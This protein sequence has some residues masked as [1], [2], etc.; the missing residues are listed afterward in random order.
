MWP[1]L[2]L[3]QVYTCLKQLLTRIIACN[4]CQNFQETSNYIPPEILRTPLRYG[5]HHDPSQMEKLRLRDCQWPKV[6]LREAVGLGPGRAFWSFPLPHTASPSRGNHQVYATSDF[7][8]VATHTTRPS[9]DNMHRVLLL[10][11]L[12]PPAAISDLLSPVNSFPGPWL[13]CSPST[14][15][16]SKSWG[17]EER[18]SIC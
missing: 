4:R 13:S 12:C 18:R 14:Q 15:A 8:R 17:G 7:S 2:Q 1:T 11:Q 10:E 9:L 16:Q 5:Y 3:L 6:T